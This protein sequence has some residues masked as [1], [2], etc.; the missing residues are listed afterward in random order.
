MDDVDEY[1]VNKKVVDNPDDRAKALEDCREERTQMV[2]TMPPME[3][4]LKDQKTA[5]VD[6]ELESFLRQ[7]TNFWYEVKQMFTSFKG[8]SEALRNKPDA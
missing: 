2:I 1:C 6:S 7:N 3:E 8:S 4:T 5:L